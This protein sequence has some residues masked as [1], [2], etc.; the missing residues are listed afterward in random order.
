MKLAAQAAVPADPQVLHSLE[1]ILK[2][3]NMQDAGQSENMQTE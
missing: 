3:L 1:T 2:K